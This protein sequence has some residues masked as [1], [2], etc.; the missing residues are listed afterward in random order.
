MGIVFV[1]QIGAGAR[2]VV[3]SI[4][5]VHEINSRLR[6]DELVPPTWDKT[7][8]KVQLRYCAHCFNCGSILFTPLPPNLCTLHDDSCP[9]IDWA[10]GFNAREFATAFV[11]LTDCA[12]IPTE[13]WLRCENLSRWDERLNGFDLA[14]M[15][16][17]FDSE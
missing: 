12:E 1:A 16:T 8:F 3:C 9:S 14:A 4:D 15:V 13:T 17:P 7:E 10:Q 11:A 6:D 5:C 2:A